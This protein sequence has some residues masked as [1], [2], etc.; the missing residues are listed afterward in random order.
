[1][2]ISNIGSLTSY[3]RL[4]SRAS[5]FLQTRYSEA[6]KSSI[7]GFAAGCLM[8]YPGLEL[9]IDLQEEVPVFDPDRF[10]AGS[11]NQAQGH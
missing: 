8:A 5:N 2:N 10:S 1:M 11:R 6:E 4:N 7:R 3:F 9:I